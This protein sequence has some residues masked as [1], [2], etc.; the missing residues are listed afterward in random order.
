MHKDKAI[1]FR[2]RRWPLRIVVR[3]EQGLICH[4]RTKSQFPGTLQ[5]AMSR[6]R[7]RTQPNGSTL[8]YVQG[9]LIGASQHKPAGIVDLAPFPC[10]PRPWN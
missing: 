8:G 7:V 4:L 2:P 3:E 10:Y 9:P 5:T 6:S 1:T